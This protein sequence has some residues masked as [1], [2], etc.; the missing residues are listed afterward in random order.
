VTGDSVA[1]GL[2]HYHIR[3]RVLGVR[4]Y[5]HDSGA[6]IAPVDLALGW[7]CMSDWSIYGR[8]EISQSN[9]FYYFTWADAKPIPVTVGDMQVH[10]SNNHI[11]TAN[12]LVL[13]MLSRVRRDDVVVI[14]GD[15]VQVDGIDG[16]CWRSSLTRQD[17]GDGACELIRATN[18]VIEPR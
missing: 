8:L 11:I 16:R 2:A 17:T 12:P 18:L 3:A 7:G 6:A 14:D 15:L 13:R 4:W 10:S 5:S 9:R 1:T